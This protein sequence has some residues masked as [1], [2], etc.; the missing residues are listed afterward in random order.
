MIQII[1][2]H[3]WAIILAFITAIIIAAPQV[4]FRYD[5]Q[6]AYKGIEI[7]GASDD[8]LSFLNRVREAQDGHLSLSSTYYKEGK[9]EPYLF[10]PLG[11]DIVAL[12]GQALSL[13][14]N[15]T[16]LFSRLFF[17]FLVFILIY[18]FVFILSGQKLTALASS[19]AVL[20]ASVLLGREALFKVLS[21][22][23]P[24]TGFLMMMRPVDPAMIFIFFFGFLLCFWLFLERKQW[25]WGIASTVLLGLSFYDYLYTWTFLY[26]FCGLL[27][28]IYFFQKNWP[29][30]KRVAIILF[31]GLLI[32]IPYFVNVYKSFI[33][34]NPTLE[35]VSQRH[36][37][38]QTS[39]LT[40][41]FLVPFLFVVFL[42]FFPRE[43]RQRLFFCLALLTAPFI[44]LNQQIVTGQTLVNAHYHWYYHT[45]LGIIF[46]LVIFFYWLSKKKWEF[47]RKASAVLIIAVSVYTGILIQSASYAANKDMALQYQ[48]Y[49]QAIDWLNTNTIKD[50]V[51]FSNYEL[52]QIIAIYTP[53]NVFHHW[54]IDI[55]FSATEDRL[56]NTLFL[57]YRLDGVG[58]EDAREVFLQDR[59][60]I[61][62][63][64]YGL[65]YRETTGSYAGIPDEVILDIVKK[66]QDSLS[67]STGDFINQLWDKYGVK[68]LV[69]DKESEPQWNLSQYTFLR[70]AAEVGKFVIYQNN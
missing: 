18:G 1:K 35:E 38:I 50:E 30:L 15:N 65:R 25:R 47:F 21:G 26:V 23:S 49:G 66:Y 29:D 68:Y 8:E 48:K 67:V 57:L 37:L 31:G 53:L 22:D 19:A 52:S 46:L 7:I 6:D 69:W 45:P 41:G 63:S 64:L 39:G 5:N 44:V 59:A 20:L 42:L 56:L 24:R 3:K 27:A 51:V 11:V 16:I 4:Y 40:L 13:D 10:M 58:K 62:W 2:D 28:L 17:S 36:G 14:L 9:D 43:N 70:K 55:S 33:H 32:A 54:T 60:K 34:V 12:S 61:S